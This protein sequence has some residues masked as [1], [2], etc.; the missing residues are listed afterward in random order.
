MTAGCDAGTRAPG[1]LIGATAG[2]VS[3]SGD[4]A[5]T[6]VRSEPAHEVNITVSRSTASDREPRVPTPPPPDTSAPAAA[7]RYPA[8]STTGSRSGQA[9]VRRRSGARDQS[10]P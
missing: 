7:R 10:G 2:A 1:L 4:G 6:R 9:A 5:P 8:P 3:G